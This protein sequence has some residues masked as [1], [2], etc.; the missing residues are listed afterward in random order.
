LQFN[1]NLAG[2]G[3]VEGDGGRMLRQFFAAGNLPLALGQ[4]AVAG[5]GDGSAPHLWGIAHQVVENH[6]DADHI[7][8]HQR[9]S[10]ALHQLCDQ[11]LAQGVLF[12]V[13]QLPELYLEDHRQQQAGKYRID[14]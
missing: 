12:L 5:G 4:Q 6:L 8:I 14:N 11:R 3:V 10:D 2:N 9:L 13:S 1:A 7:L